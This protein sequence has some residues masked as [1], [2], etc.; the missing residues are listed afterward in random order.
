MHHIDVL[1]KW[2]SR[3][4]FNASNLSKLKVSTALLILIVVLIFVRCSPNKVLL[5]NGGAT[6]YVSLGNIYDDVKLP[7]TISSWMWVDP[8]VS[9]QTPIFASQNKDNI[10]NGFW[11]VINPTHLFAGYGDGR[12]ENNSFFRRDKTAEQSGNFGKWIH[13]AAVIRGA[14]DMSIYLNGVD[15]GGEYVGESFFTMKSNFP[16]AVAEI[17]SLDTNGASYIFKGKMDDLRIWNRALTQQEIVEQMK[18]KTTILHDRLIGYWN[19]EDAGQD[20]LD[21][22]GKNNNGIMNSASRI[23]EEIPGLKD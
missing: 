22:S 16:N 10:Y 5:C 17:G 20:V 13:V 9:T 2:P 21:R 15:I 11:F 4:T 18:K 23:K 8:S 1:V 12:G 19:F 3:I 6:D 14:T 7:V